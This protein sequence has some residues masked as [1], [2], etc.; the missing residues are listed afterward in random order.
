[1]KKN[2]IKSIYTAGAVCVMMLL[3]SCELDRLPETTLADNTFWQSET[4]L[5]GACNKLYV[6]LPGFDHDRRADDIIGTSANGTSS[7]NWSL[8]STSG[9]WSNPYNKIGVCNNI[10]SKGAVAPLTDAQK[11]RWL[12]EAYFFRAFHFFDLVKK[13]GD[14]PLILKAFDS[15][16]DPDIK[17]ARTPREEV[18]QQCYSDLRFAEEWLPEIDAVSSDADWGR[19]SKSAA[20]GLM[21]RI[22]LYEGTFSK[23][24][25]L[26]SDS[27]AHLKIAV[28]AAERLINSGKHALY[29]DYQKLFYFDGEGRQNK[30]NVFVKVYGPNGAGATIAHG[31]SRQLENGVSV[32]RQAIDQYLYTDGLPREKS[33]LAMIP[34][35]HYDDIFE[36]RDPRLGMTIYHKGEEAYK[37]GYV[38]FSNQHG[39]GYGIK[40]GFM[41]DE[42][43]TNSKE[44]VDKMVIRYAEVLLS[45]AEALYEL[46]GSITDEQLNLTV[47]AVRARS[48]FSAKLTNDFAKQNGLNI[49]DEIRRERLVEFIDEGL[50]YNDIIRWKIAEK[51][52]PTTMLGLKYNEDDTN[53]Q[54]ED[55]QSRLT[56]EGGMYKGQKVCDQADIYVIEE[57]AA[58]SFNPNKDY[59]YPIPTY[60]IATS[61]GNVVQNA[62]W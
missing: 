9:D 21:M 11:N 39:N 36:K 38:P 42:W 50:R 14:V 15:T 53:A 28:D 59:Y 43:T 60:E 35:T 19:V 58:R 47:N 54:R 29:P 3:T 8:P 62:G 16:S 2:I 33:K 27:K 52:L 5:R 49:L 22:G 45:Y 13:Y 26:S 12:A 30:E 41:L 7:G 40:K 46:N 37:G 48:G 44:T 57:A 17:M 4:D 55:L 6:D 25:G 20:R 32:T 34:E 56:T 18:I 1:M 31:N 10:I 61:E 23:Y 24:H 51:V